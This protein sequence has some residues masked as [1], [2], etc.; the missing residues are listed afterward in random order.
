MSTQS[1]TTFSIVTS[2]HSFRQ[3][4]IRFSFFR[5]GQWTVIVAIELRERRMSQQRALETAKGEGNGAREPRRSKSRSISLVL[6]PPSKLLLTPGSSGCGRGASKEPR[7]RQKRRRPPCWPVHRLL[8]GPEES[9]L[10]P[11]FSVS[12]LLFCCERA[13]ATN[14]HFFPLFPLVLFFHA[15]STKASSVVEDAQSSFASRR[16]GGKAATSQ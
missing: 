9:F 12:Q 11:L 7:R 8:L 3:P 5:R 6:C 15:R 2:L 16:V 14:A 10:S 1:A 13:V 4:F